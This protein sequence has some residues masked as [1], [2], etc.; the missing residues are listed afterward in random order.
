RHMPGQVRV[1]GP[2]PS[3]EIDAETTVEVLWS[4]GRSDEPALRITANGLSI[5]IPPFGAPPIDPPSAWRATVLL[6]PQRYH[7]VYTDP[8]FLKRTGVETV[9]AANG[10]RGRTVIVP[11]RALSQGTAQT[12]LGVRSETTA[13][14]AFTWDGT[15]YTI[16]FAE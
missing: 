11:A 8:G 12:P 15:G 2:P 3:I 1:A 10:P 16:E 4:P 6:L 13:P 5:L 14:V 9:V 7:P